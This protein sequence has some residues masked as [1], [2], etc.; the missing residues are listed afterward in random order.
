MDS[1]LGVIVVLLAVSVGAVTAARAL[2]LPPLVGYL[3]VGVLLGPNALGL[4][5]DTDVT[6]WLAEIG[7]VFL[8]FSIGL[9]FSL[10]KLR[11]MRSLVFGLGGI[12]VGLTLVL[13]ATL[14]GLTQAW[15]AMPWQAGVALGGALAMSS[16]AMVMRLAGDRGELESAH[17]KPVVGVLLF[18]DLAVVPLLVLIPALSGLTGQSDQGLGWALSMAM[19]KS[20]LVLGLALLIG[21]RLVRPWLTLVAR[22]KSQELF[23]LN[24][25]LM[26]LGLALLT[27]ARRFFGGHADF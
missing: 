2:K 20:L 1:L 13:V 24:V 27:G 26:T 17:G 8:M 22:R 18:Q 12:Q 19:A 14:I 21:Q 15:H 5:P 11:A 6:R 4:A 23:T 3:S 7:V 25:L 9:E 16:T 10:P